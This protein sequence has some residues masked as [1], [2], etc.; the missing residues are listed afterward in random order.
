VLFD[1]NGRGA[2]ECG[3]PVSAASTH[4]VHQSME[5]C[6]SVLLYRTPW[7]ESRH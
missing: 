1:N 4:S 7:L 6:I 3:R 2:G 5:P